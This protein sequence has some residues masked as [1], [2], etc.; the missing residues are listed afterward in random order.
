MKKYFVSLA[1]KVPCN[2]E[3]KIIAKSEKEALEKALEKW[4]EK[5]DLEN[6]TEPMWDELE[7]DTE[8]K[9]ELDIAGNGVYIQ[10]I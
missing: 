7:L 1:L 8:M 6:V 10:E 2:F 3:V 4:D 9:T 5:D